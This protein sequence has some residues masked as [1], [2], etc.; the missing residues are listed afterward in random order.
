ARI[1]GQDMEDLAY[2]ID[3]V[4]AH[5]VEA[6]LA[7]V[8]EA[9]TLFTY[10]PFTEAQERIESLDQSLAS[11]VTSGNAQEAARVI[12]LLSEQTGKSIEEI[13]RDRTSTRLNS[14]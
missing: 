7:T 9:L 11:M 14:S 1:R 5:P 8:A 12:E 4:S 3:S 2:A 13:K 10:A 6:T